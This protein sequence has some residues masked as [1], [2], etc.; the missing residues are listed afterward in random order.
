MQPQKDKPIVGLSLLERL[1]KDKKIE[2]KMEF[3]GFHRIYELA[4]TNERKIYVSFDG[5]FIGVALNVK[6]VIE[7]ISTMENIPTTKYD[8][9]K[10]ETTYV[11]HEEEFDRK[12]KEELLPKKVGATNGLKMYD[13]QFYIVKKGPNGKTSGTTYCLYN[14]KTRNLL[15]AHWDKSILIGWLMTKYLEIEHLDV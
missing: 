13:K 12:F 2:F 8:E 7:L 3:C 1:L 10:I 11:Y 15:W 6:E 9:S 4:A 14:F 5:E